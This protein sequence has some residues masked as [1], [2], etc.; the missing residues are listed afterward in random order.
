[1]SKRYLFFSVPS[2][3]KCPAVKKFLATTG[4]KGDEIDAST[5]DGLERAMEH[6]VML[7]PTVIFLDASGKEL[8]RASNVDEVKK[9]LSK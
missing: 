8:C 3:S 2:C 6:D 5:D 9:C 4:L 1:M 7:T